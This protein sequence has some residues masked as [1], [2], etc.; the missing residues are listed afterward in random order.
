MSYDTL[1]LS[2]LF[3]TPCIGSVRGSYTNHVEL[4]VHKLNTIGLLKM[5]LYK[6]LLLQDLA[7]QDANT[8]YSLLTGTTV[9]PFIL[10]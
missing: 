7:A 3:L 8:S 9:T 4:K 1:Y 5:V 10:S 6:D 2:K